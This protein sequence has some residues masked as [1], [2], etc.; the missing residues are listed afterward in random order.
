M[1][2]AVRSGFATIALTNMLELEIAI[3]ITL[4]PIIVAV[5]I[6][7]IASVAFAA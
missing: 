4:E 6:A 2:I 5:V 1:P 7:I 3:A